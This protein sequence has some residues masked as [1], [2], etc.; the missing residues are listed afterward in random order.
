MKPSWNERN[1]YEKAVIVIQAIIAVVLVAVMVYSLIAH[2]ELTDLLYIVIAVESA[3]EATV[4]WNRNRKA[5]YLSIAVVVSSMLVFL[6]AV[7]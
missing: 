4:Q 6:Q 7:L 5:A 2:K 1:T 3:L